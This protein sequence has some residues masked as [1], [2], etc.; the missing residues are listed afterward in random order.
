M[1]FLFLS[2]VCILVDEWNS[3]STI[4]VIGEFLTRLMV[5]KDTVGIL[6]Y[7]LKLPFRSSTKFTTRAR[8][9]K[10]RRSRKELWFGR[11]QRARW[12]ARLARLQEEE[13]EQNWWGWDGTATEWYDHWW[14]DNAHRF[15]HTAHYAKYFQDICERNPD[16]IDILT[17][18]TAFDFQSGPDHA[19]HSW[20][21]L[22]IHLPLT[23]E[24]Q[25]EI[26]TNRVVPSRIF[27]DG[28]RFQTDYHTYDDNL[29][30]VFDTGATISVS[31]RK[32]DF[33]SWD[34]TSN[35]RLTLRGITAATDVL[36]VGMVRWILH[37]D[38]GQRH[39]IETKA[40]YVPDARV[41]LLS[42]QR[43][44]HERNDGTFSI[45]PNVSIFNFPSTNITLTF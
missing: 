2:G 27:S 6:D 24:T 1:L 5:L 20:G 23:D 30:M 19:I 15:L 29:P 10:K 36:G 38:Q 12:R 33:I 45:T 14:H 41:R 22:D 17:G 18:I 4:M 16:I 31:P 44:L 42:P 32:E 9:G 3:M 8:H 43:Y 13:N 25:K 40:Y 21:F 26:T 7:L 11:C 34:T 35:S 37:D 39:L 28:V